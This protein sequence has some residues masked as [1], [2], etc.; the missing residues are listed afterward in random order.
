MTRVK[1]CGITSVSDAL[2]AVEVGADAIGL[3][4]APS[5][6]KVLVPVAKAIIGAL[7]PMITIV[8]VFMDPVFADLE[9]L[10]TEIRLDTVQLHGTES[11]QYCSRIQG[12]KVIKRFSVREEDTHQRLT[13]LMAPYQVA[14]YL[15]DPGA[16]SGRTFRWELARGFKLPLILSGGLTPENVG[17]AIRAVRPYAVDVCTGVEQL[18]GVKDRWKVRAFVEAARAEDAT[19][20]T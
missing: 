20:T 2:A 10:L 7:P 12:V 3:V 5:P 9:S 8:G 11:P 4:F 19:F 17:E 13:E 15:I 6:R 18:P 1:I 14:A 16:G